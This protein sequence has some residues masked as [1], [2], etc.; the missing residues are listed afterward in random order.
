MTKKVSPV[1]LWSLYEELTPS[2]EREEEITGVMRVL[3][4]LETSKGGPLSALDPISI[5]Y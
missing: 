3:K 4:Y 5:G 2:A 1:N